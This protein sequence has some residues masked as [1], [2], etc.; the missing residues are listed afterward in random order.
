MKGVPKEAIAK[1]WPNISA[2]A[3]TNENSA[4]RNEQEHRRTEL[5]VEHEI[6]CFVPRAPSNQEHIPFR[7]VPLTTYHYSTLCPMVIFLVPFNSFVSFKFH[8]QNR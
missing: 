5:G 1:G 3:G 7:C 2:A 6:C 8:E 4:E